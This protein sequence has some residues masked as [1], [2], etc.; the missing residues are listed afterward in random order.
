MRE[1]SAKA[2][3]PGSLPIGGREPEFAAAVAPRIG[4]HV[5]IAGGL[6]KAVTRAI[7]RGC[8][9]LQIF[10]SSPRVWRQRGHRPEE[11]A[12]FRLGLAHARIAPLF[13]HAAYLLNLASADPVLRRRSISLLARTCCSAH[14]LGASAV[15]VHCGSCDEHPMTAGLRRT[16]R[17]LAETLRRVPHSVVVDLEMTSGRPGSIG[18]SLAHFAA[19]LDLVHGEPR[20]RV[21]VDTAHA[22]AA[23]Y[24]LRRPDGLLRL[25]SGLAAFVGLDRVDGV[26]ANDSKAPCGSRCDRHENIGEGHIGFAPFAAMMAHPAFRTLPFILET[27]GFDRLGPDLKNMRRLKAL[28]GP[29][30]PY[31]P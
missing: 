27:P 30:A 4:C 23:G 28:R 13:V 8:E 9:C 20:V 5:S 18:G 22:F 12:A 19:I 7:E 2:P 17:S 21:F 3:D 1:A 11:V 10:A 24:D 26:H 14:F 6:A 31:A 15:I 25:A 29:R 16:A